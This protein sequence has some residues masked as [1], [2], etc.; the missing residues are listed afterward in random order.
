MT[1][2]YLSGRLPSRLDLPTHPVPPADRRGARAAHPPEAVT[3]HGNTGSTWHFSAQ[4]LPV[5]RITARDRRLLPCIFTITPVTRGD[6][7]CNFLWHS[8]FQALARRDP[9]LHRCAAL[10]CPD[11]PPRP[12]RRSD[13]PVCNEY[14]SPGLAP[15][16]NLQPTKLR[17]VRDTEDRSR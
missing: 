14:L 7:G 6:R 3:R 9:A 13:G 5:R 4:G 1:T 2:I 11:F 10:Y 12:E 17:Y 16:S 15:G 8:L